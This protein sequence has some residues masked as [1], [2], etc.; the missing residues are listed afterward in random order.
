MALKP[1]N[2]REPSAAARRRARKI[3]QRASG[4]EVVDRASRIP[5]LGVSESTADF[6]HCRSDGTDLSNDSC[7]PSFHMAAAHRR[8]DRRDETPVPSLHDSTTPSHQPFPLFH[9]IVRALGSKTKSA[10]M[11]SVPTMLIAAA[12]QGA[13]IAADKAPMSMPP[14]SNNT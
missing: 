6:A 5:T 12:A 7:A 14:R 1:A 8:H 10:T 9:R 13:P 11:Q 3:W 2:T 4:S